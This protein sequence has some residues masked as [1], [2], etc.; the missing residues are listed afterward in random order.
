[1]AALALCAAAV[2]AQTAEEIVRR[3]QANQ[4]FG[5]SRTEG[6]MTVKDRFGTKVTTF[7]SYARGESD[8]L[9]EFTS[10][11]ERGQKILRTQDEIY[12]FYPEARE[13]IRL[14]G[15]AFRDAVMGSDMSYEDLTGGRT[16]LESYDL[17]LLG[18]ETVDGAEC[19]K[20]DMRAKARNVAYPRQT[21]W[22]DTRLYSARRMEQYS[23]S[24]RLL[25]EI[26]LTDFKQIAGLTV[27][28][29]MVLQDKLKRNS[30]TE[31]VMEKLEIGIPVDPSL[32]SLDNL[33]W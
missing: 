4:V 6:V 30:S 3:M 10:P 8:T 22:V 23:L 13:L 33:T 14:Q 29:R 18:R 9:I 24:N 12:L 11:E 1:M 21:V 16:L 32:F 26:H 17:T 19:F 25:K 15:A 27:P 31:F 5:T 7:V 2:G 20:I 28:T